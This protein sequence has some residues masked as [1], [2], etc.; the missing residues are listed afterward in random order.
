MRKKTKE[1]IKQFIRRRVWRAEGE[2]LDSIS[3]TKLRFFL[4]N[5]FHECG[6]TIEEVIDALLF[7]LGVE[8]VVKRK[9]KS[10]RVEKIKKIK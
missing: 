4:S 3:K 8:V 10:V 5:S 9:S 7:Y 1:E 6:A 2:I